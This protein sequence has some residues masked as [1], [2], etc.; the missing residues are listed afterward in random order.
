MV[1]DALN[2]RDAEDDS[3]PYGQKDVSK[4]VLEKYNQDYEQ[5]Q[6]NQDA[7]TDQEQDLALLAI[8]VPTLGMKPGSDRSPRPGPADPDG[9]LRAGTGKGIHKG[10][11][12][13]VL[14]P[15]YHGKHERSVMPP[16][17]KTVSR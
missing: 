12:I 7:K 1:A 6:N 2:N 8:L 9:C 15:G 14:V 3:N 16:H 17:R 4:Y 13:C 5:N 10:A 11:S